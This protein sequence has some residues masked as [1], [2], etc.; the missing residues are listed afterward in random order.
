MFTNHIITVHIPCSDANKMSIKTT[1]HK[2]SY[3]WVINTDLLNTVKRMLNILT[4]NICV[5]Y[6]TKSIKET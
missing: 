5:L 3:L 4:D 6:T 1:D 2:T